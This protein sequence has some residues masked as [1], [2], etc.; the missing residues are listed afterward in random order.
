MTFLDLPNELLPFIKD[1]LG[2]DLAAHVCYFKLCARTQ[3][4][5]DDI[6]AP[7]AFWKRLVRANGLGLSK[8]ET[9]TSE[10]WKAIAMRCGEHAQRCEHPAC[11]E[12]RLEE[13]RLLVQKAEAEWREW[14]ILEAVPDC[15]PVSWRR[16]TALNTAVPSS[17]TSTSPTSSHHRWTGK[18]SV[19]QQ[20]RDVLF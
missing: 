18:N 17:P 4:C 11:G 6:S 2:C 7:P 16:C 13:N 20:S 14:D 10:R 15:L 1:G 8:L 3:A 9:D 5:Y 12:R 19:R